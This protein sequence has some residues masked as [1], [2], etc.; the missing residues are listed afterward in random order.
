[1]NAAKLFCLRLTIRALIFV[2]AAPV[3]A[4]AAI[5]TI[6]TQSEQVTA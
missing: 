4:I 2:I 3:W 1:M 5:L 6:T